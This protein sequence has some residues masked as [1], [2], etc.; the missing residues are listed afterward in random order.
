[1]N[2]YALVKRNRPAK[3]LPPFI[4]LNKWCE[5]RGSERKDLKKE[6]RWCRWERLGGGGINNFSSQAWNVESFLFLFW[7]SISNAIGRLWNDNR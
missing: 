3:K 6:K 1:M 5:G 4:Q 2:G 7:S